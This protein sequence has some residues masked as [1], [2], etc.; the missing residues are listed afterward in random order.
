MIHITYSRE[1][2]P[3]A[4]QVRDDL[5]SLPPP[6]QPLLIVLV[7]RQSNA[8]PHV[9]AEI[10]SALAEGAR[11]LPILCE[12]SPLPAALEGWPPLDFNAGYD[13][14]R[15]LHWLAPAKEPSE[16]LRRANRR[17]LAIIGGIALLVFAIALV[18]INRG[19]IAFPVAEYNEDATFQAEWV[20]GLIG[21]TLEAVQPRTTEDARNFAATFEVAP[22]RLYLYI[23]ETAT[24]L[25]KAGGS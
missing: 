17:G 13:R 5:A 11:V 15:L 16:A 1:Q 10:A 20:N 6:P 4:E 21:E 24:A 22:T 25:P 2:A 14:E 18:T 19:V 3:L 12:T 8:D 7:S 23:R 9:Q